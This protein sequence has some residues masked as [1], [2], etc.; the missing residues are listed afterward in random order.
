[1]TPGPHREPAQV[2]GLPSAGGALLARALS[3]VL[4]R[5]GLHV[6]VHGRPRVPDSGPVILASNHTGLVDGPMLI[7]VSPR[8]V[9]V[10]IKSEAFRGLVG[11]A[12]VR[13][14]QIALRRDGGDRAAITS[15]LDVL[16]AGRVLAIF[17]EGTRGAGDVSSVQRGVAH[18][19]LRSG[20]PVVPVAVLGTAAA[21]PGGAMPRA[22]ALVDVLF[23]EPL[24]LTATG[25]AAAPGEPGVARAATR[26][27]TDAALETIKAAMAANVATAVARRA[28]RPAPAAPPATAAPVVAP[29]ATDAPVV[30]HRPSAAAGPAHAGTPAAGEGSA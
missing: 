27:A 25:A 23:G 2:P 20:A 9:H 29:P 5:T 22:R 19:A 1:M 4:F 14:G 6:R 11:G 3:I 18:L 12:L 10:L 8:P 24:T 17:P 28:G 21:R 15:A 7:G 30:A 13:L 16:R 26:A